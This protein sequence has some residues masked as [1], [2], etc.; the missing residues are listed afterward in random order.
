MKDPM[1]GTTQGE[2]TAPRRGLRQYSLLLVKVTLSVLVL[3][4]IVRTVDLQASVAV[5]R[6]IDLWD[7]AGATVLLAS[8]VAIVAPRWGAILRVFGHDLPWSRLLASVY[9]GFALNQMLPTV[10]GGDILRIRTG[11]KH[12]VPLWRATS[13]VLVDR[14]TGIVGALILLIF[15]VVLAASDGGAALPIALAAA[16]SSALGLAGLLVLPSLPALHLP[17]ADR[18][19]DPLRTLSRDVRDA[20]TDAEQGPVIIGLAVLA[21]MIP[22]GALYLIAKGSGLDL[23]PTSFLIYGPLTMLISTIPLSFAGWGMREGGL[24]YLFSLYNVP[25]SEALAVSVVFGGL[26]VV[27]SLP[28][29]L[30]IFYPNSRVRDA[31]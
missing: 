13:S 19:I 11:V 26:M 30:A 25:A 29:S 31:A 10:V 16:G 3:F 17:W 7:L 4:V 22:V 28:G 9:A 27:A 15:G 8:S 12:G 6:Q 5:M 14:I 24:V 21:Q 1:G 20:I 23:P 18:L 2:F